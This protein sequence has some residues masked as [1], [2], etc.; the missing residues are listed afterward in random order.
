MARRYESMRAAIEELERTSKRLF[1]AAVHGPK[2]STVRGTKGE[3]GK[4]ASAEG[5]I[6]GLF[7]RQ[8][9]VLR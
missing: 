8:L 6:E 2:F 7:P 5:R 1:D 9:P 4:K 3:Q